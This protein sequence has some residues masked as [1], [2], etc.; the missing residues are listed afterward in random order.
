M[1]GARREGAGDG[2]RGSPEPEAAVHCARVAQGLEGGARR[3]SACEKPVT[4]A[5]GPEWKPPR[6]PVLVCP[7]GQSLGEPAVPSPSRDPDAHAPQ[8]RA[9]P[10]APSARDR[11]PPPRPTLTRGRASMGQAQPTRRAARRAGPPASSADET[12]AAQ[13]VGSD[14]PRLSIPALPGGAGVR[15][16]LARAPSREPDPTPAPVVVSV[17]RHSPALP[18]APQ[19]HRCGL[20]VPS[21]PPTPQSSRPTGASDPPPAAPGPPPHPRRPGPAPA[22]PLRTSQH[23]AARLEDPPASQ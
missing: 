19:G 21:G 11:R 12:G 23:P 2:P 15:V 14:R 18:R 10:Q 6:R 4:G 7:P 5:G 8:T 16:R 1:A 9:G 20:L 3:G 13:A 17:R 22:A